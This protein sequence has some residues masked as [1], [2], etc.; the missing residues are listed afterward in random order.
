MTMTER[1]EHMACEIATRLVRMHGRV[2]GGDADACIVLAV[3]NAKR[4]EFVVQGTKWNVQRALVMAP[5]DTV[6]RATCGNRLCVRV[7]HL[8]VRPRKRRRRR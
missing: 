8:E 5:P 3:A 4:V 7:D 2:V 1:C 6:V